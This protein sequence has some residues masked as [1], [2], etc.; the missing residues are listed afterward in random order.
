LLLPLEKLL[1]KFSKFLPF[2]AAL[3][4]Y[5]SEERALEFVPIRF[6]HG[7]LPMNGPGND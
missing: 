6:L 5:V 3:S 1:L 2:S 4:E 7:K